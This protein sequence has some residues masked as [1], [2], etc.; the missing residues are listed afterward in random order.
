[1]ASLLQT[2][3][4]LDIHVYKYIQMHACI[5]ANRHTH[6]LTSTDTQTHKHKN[7]TKYNS[8]KYSYI[9]LINFQ[10]VP[11]NSSSPL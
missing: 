1:M 5:H 9:M 11:P 8:T 2:I 4:D 3:K 10:I 7:R 6:I